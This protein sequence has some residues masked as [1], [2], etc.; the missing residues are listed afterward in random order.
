M[1]NKDRTKFEIFYS[2]WSGIP[3]AAGLF[4]ICRDIGRPY[5]KLFGLNST[6]GLAYL[7]IGL[8]NLLNAFYGSSKAG[9][10]FAAVGVNVVSLGLIV[11]M[12]R[13][14][15]EDHYNFALL[16]VMAG[17]ALFSFFAKRASE[18]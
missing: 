8:L 4:Y 7:Q 14:F 1:G 9:I 17:M 12:I 2:L 16:G 3:I 13:L 18:N 10:F 15:A 11:W 6:I 5:N